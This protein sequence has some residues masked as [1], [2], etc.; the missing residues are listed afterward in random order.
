MGEKLDQYLN[1]DTCLVEVDL[2]ARGFYEQ[3]GLLVHNYDHALWDTETAI[4]IWEGER[5]TDISR[6]I[7]AA[8]MHDTGVVKPPYKDHGKNGA[9]L[10]RVHL[11][12]LGFS[13]EEVDDIATAVLEH[14][15]WDH[16]TPTSRDLYDADTLN[17]SG[18]HGIGQCRAA[19]E[20]Y[21]FNLR[22]IADRFLPYLGRLIKKGFY[23]KTA[24]EIDVEMGSG[25]PGLEVTLAYFKKIDELLREGGLDDTQILAE[26]NKIFGV[27]K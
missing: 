25:K 27:K 18:V 2:L 19:Q 13:K 16:S 14:N 17:K 10:V 22:Q 20:E 4:R 9:E 8:L 21:G 23:T 7:A 5:N 11:P 3:A 6:L 1:E 12:R 24:R 26:V 15:E